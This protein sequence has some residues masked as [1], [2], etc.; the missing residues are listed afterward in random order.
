MDIVVRERAEVTDGG[1][2]QIHHLDLGPIDRKLTVSSAGAG[3]WSMAISGRVLGDVNVLGDSD[4]GRINLGNFPA[5][6][7]KS[8]SV[9]LLA[10]RS[11]LDLTLIE[12][13]TH[14]NYV[15]VK[16]EPAE[17][18]GD[19]R[20]WRLRVTIPKGSLYGAMP[21]SSGII[22]KTNDPVPRRFR[23]PIR[24]MTYDSGGP[25]L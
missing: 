11:G 2:K 14:P 12:S 4:G 20:Q 19:R 16:L 6:Q 5:D 7:D 10:E 8:G 3:S 1:K 9:V 22:L 21:E 18:L 17:P 15:K 24:G 13:E 25:R 23:I